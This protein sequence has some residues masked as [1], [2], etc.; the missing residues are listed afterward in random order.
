MSA[1][2]PTISKWWIIHTNIIF[3]CHNIN[4]KWYYLTLG[5]YIYVYRYEIFGWITSSEVAKS[6]KIVVGEIYGMVANIKR[7]KA[8]EFYI[9]CDYLFLF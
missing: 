7:P 2:T 3:V 1:S 8:E 6:N 9:L 5:K 4:F